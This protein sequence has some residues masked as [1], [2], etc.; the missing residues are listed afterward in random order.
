MK[1]AFRIDFLAME[2]GHLIEETAA[3]MP[4]ITLPAAREN[5][6]R[7]CRSYGIMY[8]HP[9]G[10]PESITQRINALEEKWLLKQQNAG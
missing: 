7:Y 5:A 6:V 1:R 3:R 8:Y 4:Q 2:P 10:I 9:N